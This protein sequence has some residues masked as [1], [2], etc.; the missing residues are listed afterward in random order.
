MR[1]WLIRLL[2]IFLLIFILTRI[3]LS[4]VVSTTARVNLWYLA[5]AIALIIPVIFLKS[6]RWQSLLKMQ[7]ITYPL[8][9]AFLAFFGGI[10]LG[11]ATPGRLGELGRVFYLTDDKDLSFGG[12][13]SSVLVD[14]L[15][16]IYLLLLVGGY[17]LI[18]FHLI[19]GSMIVSVIILTLVLA[20]PLL[21]LN[22]RIGKRLIGLVYQAKLLRRFAGK[23]DAS[24][25]QFYSGVNRLTN[26]SLI[27]PLL[28]TLAAYAI[29]FA[30]Y[31]VLALAL[32]LS[33]SFLDIAIY[34]S[35]A[36][37]VGLIPVSIA[38]IGTRDA[39]LIVLFSLQGIGAES[40]LSYSLLV[41]FVFYICGAAMAAIA[42][43]IKPLQIS[44]G[45]QCGEGK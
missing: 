14:R 45:K 42:W 23:L 38:G 40:A 24:A 22:K 8:R 10:Y 13:F 18:A 30:Q 5:L 28:I 39:T 20:L 25:D 1:L 43:Q 32:N 7:G 15:F 21:F 41:L 26:P 29:L 35:V 31:Y 3:D 6:W 27:L 12:A 37:L 16:D 2:G 19:R 33:L 17:G 36:N 9:R 44:R 4:S 34:M 11:L